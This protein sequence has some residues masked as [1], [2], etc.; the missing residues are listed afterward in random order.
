MANNKFTQEYL[1]RLGMEEYE[2]G[3][4]RH[5]KPVQ[6]GLENALK[7]SEPKNVILGIGENAIV[8]GLKET[9][10]PDFSNDLNE[11]QKEKLKDLDYQKWF[12]KNGILKRLER[13]HNRIVD[14][15]KPMSLPVFDS[16]FKSSIDTVREEYSKNP[17]GFM[18][19]QQPGIIIRNP[20]KEIHIP[21]KVINNVDNDVH[22]FYLPIMGKVRMS[23]SDKWKTDPNHPDPKKRARKPVTKYRNIKSNISAIAKEVGF[24]LP[25]ENFEV[26]FNIEMPESWSKIKRKELAG[27]KHLTKP[28]LDNCLGSLMDWL[29]PEGDQHVWHCRGLRK[30]WSETNSIQI[31][32]WHQ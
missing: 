13:G 5:K 9:K 21:Y 16:N 22:I 10:N 27:T 7:Q 28:D 17:M 25:K 3:K 29:L 26:I 31:T 23:Q 14:Q 8:K 11:E 32:I 6:R 12:G 18:T 1:E 2:P 30:L 24:V 15:I 19:L 4:Y 20:V